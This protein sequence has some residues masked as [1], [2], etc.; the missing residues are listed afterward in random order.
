MICAGSSPAVSGIATSSDAF[1]PDPRVVINPSS[2]ACHRC[3]LGRLPYPRL[4][5]TALLLVLTTGCASRGTIA[6]PDDVIR[7][8]GALAR[9]AD[10]K[11]TVLPPGVNLAD[12]LTQDEA[13]ATALWNN[14]DFQVQLAN[15][16]FARADLVEA[17]L[18]QNPVLSLLFPLGPKQLEATL[19][20]PIDLLWQRP[21]RVA[22]A[23]LAAESIA[24]GLEQDG[25]ALVS[26]V[27]VAYTDYALARDRIALAER[28]MTELNGVATLM[29]SRFR[30]GDISQLEARTAAIDAARARQDLERAR[31]DANLRANELRARMGLASGKH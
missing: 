10:A 20:F 1:G 8:S 26:D 3:R 23:R 7:R 4:L 21:R 29:D 24:R 13:I 18:L 2:A 12:G 27:K 28:T 6:T 11:G 15:L 9:P 30:A 16:G 14:P 25:L 5:T 19:R 17:G 22:A 31:L